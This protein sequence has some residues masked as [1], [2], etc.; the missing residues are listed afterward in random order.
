MLDVQRI[1]GPMV[2]RSGKYHKRIETGNVT[3]FHVEF[4]DARKRRA[5][6][7]PAEQR[8]HRIPRPLGVKPDG[9]IR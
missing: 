6:S 5:G 2:F 4:V 9:A 8:I 7:A 3:G 1:L